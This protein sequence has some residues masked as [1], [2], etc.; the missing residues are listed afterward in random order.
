MQSRRHAEA[1]AKMSHV[2][3]RVDHG[4][5]LVPSPGNPDSLTRV[6][7]R[8]QNGGLSKRRGP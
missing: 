8:H 1:G 3:R 5:G 2:D 6:A 7:P 4:T